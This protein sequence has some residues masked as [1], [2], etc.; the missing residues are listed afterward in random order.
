MAMTRRK[1]PLSPPPSSA[2][3][4]VAFEIPASLQQFSSISRSLATH[5]SPNENTT[6][7]RSTASPKTQTLPQTQPLHQTSA[8]PCSNPSP[9]YITPQQPHQ[10]AFN[11][12]ASQRPPLPTIH[13]WPR[14]GS[15][16]RIQPSV[17]K[18]SQEVASPQQS[19][20]INPAASR[21]AVAHTKPRT[22]SHPTPT[23]A[24]TTEP[25]LRPGETPVLKT[26]PNLIASLMARKRAENEA[27]GNRER[28]Q[29]QQ[30]QYQAGKSPST[31]VLGELKADAIRT[32]S[33]PNR[34]QSRAVSS[35]LP[36]RPVPIST[37][38]SHFPIM[39]ETR[40]P[41][42]DTVS[43]DTP[44]TDQS[45]DETRSPKQRVG[46]ADDSSFNSPFSSPIADFL[47]Q[48][49]DDA[50]LVKAPQLKPSALPSAT[51]T[52]APLSS[53]RAHQQS[54]ALWSLD[55]ATM[56]ISSQI[57]IPSLFT[58][59]SQ[60]RQTLSQPIQSPFQHSSSM[61]MQQ[62]ST[63]QP[64]PSFQAGQLSLDSSVSNLPPQSPH[65]SR[66]SQAYAYANAGMSQV[67]Q[68]FHKLDFQSQFLR[69]N[70]AVQASTPL[71]PQRSFS[72]TPARQPNTPQLSRS[73]GGSGHMNI[74]VPYPPAGSVP[75]YGNAVIIP[76]AEGAGNP[77][78]MT[79]A[80]MVAGINTKFRVATQAGFVVPK[81]Y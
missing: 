16:P 8:Q 27:A 58:D 60:S 7:V 24:T 63:P 79:T 64:S 32:S 19:A 20:K 55:D 17:S 18:P 21:P 49:T 66:A 50:G 46:R 41:A 30:A 37:S 11:Q 4:R 36:A 68:D 31:Q 74:A 43:T 25:T 65:Q 23:A 13:H 34:I 62:Q 12:F 78:F 26:H 75:T 35:P 56:K 54:D 47:E 67:Q 38:N 59:N 76:Q 1:R 2:A 33:S 42:T 53:Y 39:I 9:S 5:T 6:S 72:N 61:L 22:T 81:R 77:A 44:A 15:N 3:K 70:H 52:E 57:G 80:D 73:G 40:T 69:N 45:P 71:Y 28:W 51:G 14:P 29:K 10:N 48:A